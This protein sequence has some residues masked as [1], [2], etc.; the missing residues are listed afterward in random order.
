MQ[1]PVNE[2]AHVL[3]TTSD[4]RICVLRIPT[5]GLSPPLPEHRASILVQWL[6]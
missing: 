5:V 4:P 2:R 3:N 1:E 6:K